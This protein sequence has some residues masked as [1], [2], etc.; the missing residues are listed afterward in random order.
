MRQE[1]YRNQPGAETGDASDE[2]GEQEDQQ[3]SR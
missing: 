1:G 2:V 3:G